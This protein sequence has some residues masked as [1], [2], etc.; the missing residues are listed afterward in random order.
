[1]LHALA[2]RFSVPQPET[3]E[4]SNLSRFLKPITKEC[5][6][7][8]R[9]P[10]QKQ[11]KPARQILSSLSSASAPSFVLLIE[12]VLGSL[13]R[14][15]E[16]ADGIA[17]QREILET[18][19]ELLR[20]AIIVYGTWNST[21]PEPEIPNPLL[22]FKDSLSDIF[23]KS[24]T[25]SAK[26]ETAFRLS[27]IKGLLELSTLRNYLQD[28][29]IGLFVQYLND[30][31]L[32]EASAR[33]NLRKDAV[34]ALA[35]VSKYK[36]N[37]IVDITFPALI[38]TLPDSDT[39]TDSQYLLILDSLAKISVEREVLNTLVKRLL[40][41]LET[42][43][44]PG[45]QN[46]SAY[47]GAILM[48]I[49]YSMSHVKG[50]LDGAHLE[51]YYDKIVRSL[52]RR[53]A[54]ASLKKDDLTVL[55][56]P[57]VLDTLGRLCNF[58]VRSLPRT[59]Q[60][61]VSKN[62]YNLYAAE[63]GFVPIPFSKSPTTE[64]Q[65]QTALLSTYLLA[66]LPKDIT[67]LQY[68]TPSII[69]LIHDVSELAISE[70]QNVYTQF[71]LVQQV[72]LLIN[73]FLP[74]S[75]QQAASSLLFSLIVGSSPE[76]QGQQQQQLSQQTVQT[77]FWISK[78]LVLRLAPSTSEILTSLLKLLESP[79]LTTS[80]LSAQGFS[81]LL[82]EDDIISKE[83][84]ANIRLLSKQRVFTTLIP[85]IS[86]KVQ[87]ANVNTNSTATAPSPIS[88]SSPKHAKEAYLTALS[89]LLSTI[90]S[91]L[92]MTK[93]ETLLPLLLQ[94]LDLTSTDAET[95]SI[96]SATLET[97]AVI[98]RENG[99]RVI[100]DIGYVEDLVTRLLRTARIS[101]SKPQAQEQT[102]L[103]K[104]G[105]PSGNNSPRIRARALQCLFILAKNPAGA[106]EASKQVTVSPLLKLKGTVVRSLG[107]V[108]DDPKRDVR[109]AA[110]DARAAWLRDV[111]DEPEHD[112]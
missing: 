69:P 47:A 77:I 26:D 14:V 49:S 85:L 104:S 73:K 83:N 81:I 38:S 67:S 45:N 16:E 10:Q 21:D 7:Q 109:K 112:D 95:Q 12:A 80:H 76:E 20:S 100:N 106:G 46:S 88:A 52:C 56:E 66:A 87:Q 111:E 36:P 62:V 11:A 65:R 60:D 79:D 37:L 68:A 39:A 72:A 97:L 89:G 107:L 40:S 32:H 15:Y 108:L 34:Q 51:F 31:I 29:E 18:L 110:V 93:L 55:N 43:L 70:E 19:V 35:E 17:K 91:S 98:I 105:V 101:R 48:T 75:E 90:P 59:I 54:L 82:A 22:P 24:L 42:V 3:L 41:K 25:G 28:N 74:S 2:V 103:D 53:A 57:R 58:I 61:E 71:A 64:H 84:G 99:V 4:P 33:N 8:L 5:N 44:Q 94:S 9:E 6:E 1:M 102:Q 23:N 13:I 78:A 63:D 50:V 96:K 92:V 27:A 86:E 30:I